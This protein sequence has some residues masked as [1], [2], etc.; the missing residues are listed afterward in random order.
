MVVILAAGNDVQFAILR[1]GGRRTGEDRNTRPTR[2]IRNREHLLLIQT[3]SLKDADD[4][5][6]AL[7]AAGV[8]ASRCLN[9]VLTTTA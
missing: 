2:G 7:E 3:Y 5:I 6:I 4:W 9:R 8:R 1:G